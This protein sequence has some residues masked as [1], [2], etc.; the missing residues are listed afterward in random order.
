MKSLLIAGGTGF[1][2]KSFISA[3]EAGLLAKW[4]IQ[5]LIIAARH[6]SQ[7]AQ[8]TQARRTPNVFYIDLDFSQHCELPDCDYI[9]HFAGSSDSAA[10]QK[11][12]NKEIHNL[13]QNMLSF[14]KSIERSPAKPQNILFVSSGAVYGP[15]SDNFFSETTPLNRERQFACSKQHYARAKLFSERTFCRLNKKNRKLSIARAFSFV[16]PSLP[17]NSHFVAGNL[18]RNILMQEPLH[19]SAFHSVKRSYLHT[20]DLIVWLME[21]LLNGSRD[22]EIFN[23]GSDDCVEIHKLAKELA[24]KFN[25]GTDIEHIS[26]SETD[27]YVPDITKA[28][29]IGLEVRYSSAEA[30]LRTIKTHQ[31]RLLRNCV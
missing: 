25:L 15:T 30:I 10:Y 12:L 7:F 26:N 14:V 27:L 4:G 21:I 3:F 24:N 5:Q 22:G 16:G 18:I 8:N 19:V 11:N 2:G 1:F 17:L 6:A 28:R 13:E 9:M 31:H 23:V 29:S 20:D